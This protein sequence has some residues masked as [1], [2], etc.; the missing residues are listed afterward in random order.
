MSTEGLL[1]SAISF[2]ALRPDSLDRIVR[3][4][5]SSGSLRR[6]GDEFLAPA[7]LALTIGY[8]DSWGFASNS[9]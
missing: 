1:G 5:K 3:Y 6:V 8:A 4:F 2:P 7:G 9:S